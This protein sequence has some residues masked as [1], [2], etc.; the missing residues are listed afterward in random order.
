MNDI[1]QMRCNSESLT[2]DLEKERRGEN[3]IMQIKSISESLVWSEKVKRIEQYCANEKH[4]E[5]IELVEIA[6]NLSTRGEQY[7]TVKLH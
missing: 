7:Y 4:V 5:I 6:R 2:T 3:N 1:M